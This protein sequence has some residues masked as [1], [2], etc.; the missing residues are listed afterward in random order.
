MNCDKR[1][2]G[3]QKN[4]T[5]HIGSRI[6]QRLLAIAIVLGTA[7]ALSGVFASATHEYDRPNRS[8][9]GAPNIGIFDTLRANA[10]T[11]AK[12]AA[13]S[14][15]FGIKP[16]AAKAPAVRSRAKPRTGMPAKIN[17]KPKSVTLGA[18]GRKSA[19][20]AIAANNGDKAGKKSAARTAAVQT[21]SDRASMAAS[22]GTTD[23]ARSRGSNKAAA[24][25]AP[26]MLR[27]STNACTGSSSTA[28]HGVAGKPC[29]RLL[30]SARRA[31]AKVKIWNKGTARSIAAVPTVST[32]AK[33]ADTR[34]AITPGSVQDFGANIGRH[35]LFGFDKSK[36]TPD[37]MATLDKQATW[38][39]R[40]TKVTAV[41]EGHA[42][43]RGPESYNLALGERRAAAIRDY[44]IRKGV[45]A[46]RV[47]T[48]SYGETR[49]VAQGAT[50]AAWAKNRGGTIF[51]LNTDGKSRVTPLLAAPEKTQSSLS[52]IGS[53][54]GSGAARPAANDRSLG[55]TAPTADDEIE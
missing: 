17:F 32:R 7:L 43:A 47:K 6:V 52:G 12:L 35:V 53:G 22:V 29:P 39:K 42:D 50:E 34:T 18:T 3:D 28:G 2:W 33:S 31:A 23:T 44:L 40:H 45:A 54:A 51:V 9:I 27:T 46:N 19:R 21:A 1:K 14:G 8:D 37:A 48:I 10:E 11:A 30:K 4:E 26:A 41:V 25:A 13:A 16:G 20:R 36:L 49:P 38:L 5:R 55:L 24:S 15:K